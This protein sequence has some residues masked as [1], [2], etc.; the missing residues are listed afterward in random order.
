MADTLFILALPFFRSVCLFRMSVLSFSPNCWSHSWASHD[1]VRPFPL[2]LLMNAPKL[3]SM[4]CAI[5]GMWVPKSGH[6]IPEASRVDCSSQVIESFDDALSVVIPSKQPS[7]SSK[8]PS[9]SSTCMGSL[10]PV[11][12]PLTYYR[13]LAFALGNAVVINLIE[14]KCTF[15]NV[16]IWSI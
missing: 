10:A 3:S 9:T 15:R 16:Y 7:A 11:W 6:L 14:H 5:H 12:W 2:R 8:R 1:L 4:T 13:Q